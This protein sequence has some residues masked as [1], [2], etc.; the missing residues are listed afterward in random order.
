MP[1]LEPMSGYG[2]T[3][4]VNGNCGF[5]AAPVSQDP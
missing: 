3:T 5:A 4:S 1:N 2:I